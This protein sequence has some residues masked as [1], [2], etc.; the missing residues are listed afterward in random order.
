[1]A[2]F[3]ALMR[4]KEEGRIASFDM[5]GD[6]KA[7]VRLLSGSQI[8][9]YMSDQYIIGEA[10]VVEAAE[11]PAAAFVVYNNW[12]TVGQG[13]FKEATRRAIEVHK[14]AAFA[15]RLDELNRGR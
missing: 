1:M 9:V 15:Y 7:T 14:F 8:L 13:A 12:D 4:Y 5:H 6:K 2:L 10:D 3:N 11:H